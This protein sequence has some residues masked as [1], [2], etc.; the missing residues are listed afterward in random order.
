MIKG[1]FSLKKNKTVLSGNFFLRPTGSGGGF[2][3]I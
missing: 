1:K 2:M 3:R